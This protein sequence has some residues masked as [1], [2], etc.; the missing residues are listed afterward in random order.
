MEEKIRLNKDLSESK[1]DLLDSVT[2]A[3]R[4]ERPANYLCALLN[5]LNKLEDEHAVP[6]GSCS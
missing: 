1:E 3:M 6:A 2:D 5:K 4:C